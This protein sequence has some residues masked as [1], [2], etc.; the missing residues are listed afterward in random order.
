MRTLTREKSM[1]INKEMWVL[2]S[3]DREMIE[4]EERAI[5]YMEYCVTRRYEKILNA[6]MV[7]G[8]LVLLSLLLFNT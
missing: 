3:Y 5:E 6:L 2:N 8:G 1:K 4:R 7:V